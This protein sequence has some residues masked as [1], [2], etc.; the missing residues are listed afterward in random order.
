MR[1]GLLRLAGARE[2]FVDAMIPLE[3]RMLS[4][5]VVGALLP[6]ETRQAA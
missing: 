4:R 5:L 3:G 6:S 1:Q 2:R